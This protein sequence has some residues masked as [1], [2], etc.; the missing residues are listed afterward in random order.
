MI[1]AF[2]TFFIGGIIAMWVIA[3][4]VMLLIYLATCSMA[5]ILGMGGLLVECFMEVF[6]TLKWLYNRLT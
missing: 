2:I 1:T 3:L 4:T 5:F 6:D